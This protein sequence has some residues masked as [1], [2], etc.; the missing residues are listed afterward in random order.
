MKTMLIAVLSAAT[1]G[2]I[3]AS[4]AYSDSGQAIREPGIF[5]YAPNEMCT[6]AVERSPQGGFLQLSVGSHRDHLIHVADDV[7]AILWSSPRSLV[8]SVGPIYGKPGVFLVTCASKPRI[9]KLVGAQ[10]KDKAYPDGADYFEVQSISGREIH[11]LYGADVDTID[12][13][14]WRSD[15]NLRTVQMPTKE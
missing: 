7:T 12:F 4:V 1:L 14:H 9:S 10:H 11:Y 3:P 5:S 8:Y 6:A 13:T 15:G 2:C